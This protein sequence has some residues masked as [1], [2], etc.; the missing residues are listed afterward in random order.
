VASLESEIGATRPAGK[1]WSPCRGGGLS[2]LSVKSAPM[3]RGPEGAA[4]PE[5]TRVLE[6]LDPAYMKIARLS[7]S[8]SSMVSRQS[9]EKPR[10]RP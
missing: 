5:R 1:R 9:T 10:R 8:I 2:S 6:A 3:E 7:M 4:A